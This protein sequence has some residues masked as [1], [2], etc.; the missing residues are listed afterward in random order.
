MSDPSRKPVGAATWTAIVLGITG[1]VLLIGILNSWF[2]P[3]AGM[4]A[5]I[6]IGLLTAAACALAVVG[7]VRGERRPLNWIALAVSAPPLL[8]LIMF[9]LGEF[10]GP[11]H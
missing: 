9:G 2:L 5:A 3:E 1:S 8:F 7:L 10:L 6:L 11:A 4:S